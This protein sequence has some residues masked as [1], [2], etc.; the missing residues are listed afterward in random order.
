MQRYRPTAEA[1]GDCEALIL[2]IHSKKEVIVVY[3]DELFQ[4]RWQ[5]CSS[6]EGGDNVVL[7]RGPMWCAQA[8]GGIGR[9]A[10]IAR[11]PRG[12]RVTRNNGGQV[13]WF[14]GQGNTSCLGRKERS[15]LRYEKVKLAQGQV[16]SKGKLGASW[17]QGQVGR[18]RTPRASPVVDEYRNFKNIRDCHV[19]VG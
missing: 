11:I 4:F 16:G 2:G 18:K 19:Y 1:L 15:A 6:E 14:G 5:C 3:T 13:R 9:R 17:E 12:G 7:T 8:A 10:H